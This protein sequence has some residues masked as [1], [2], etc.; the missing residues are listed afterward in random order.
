MGKLNNGGNMKKRKKKKIKTRKLLIIISFFSLILSYYEFNS[1]YSFGSIIRDIIFLPSRNINSKMLLNS[2]E[3]EI[4]D[5]NENL[6]NILDINY[7]LSE[8][9]VVNATIVERN[10]SFWF[11]E[12][13][14]N[15]GIIDNV[16]KNMIAVTDD[17]V[18][19]IVKNS[20]LFTSKIRLL[21]SNKNVVSVS[22]NGNNKLM[23][24]SNNKLF[25]NGINE[26]DNIKVGDS[27]LTSGLSDIFPRG[28]LIGNICELIKNNDNVGYT[29]VVALSSDINDLRFISVL[30]RKNK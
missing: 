5:E 25:I 18:V 22:I 7:S 21:T 19:G 2:L 1:D 13:T 3:S 23:S 17:G 27:V 9:D 6:K 28:L 8:F 29:G 20:S 16:Y 30:R 4:I 11:E 15:R 14:I 10:S 12:F 24:S 26:K